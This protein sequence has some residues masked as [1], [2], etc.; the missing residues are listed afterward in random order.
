MGDQEWINATFLDVN[1]TFS[2]GKSYNAHV[3][4]G[5]NETHLFV[6]AIIFKAGPNPYTVPDYVTRPDGFQ[7]YFDVNNDANLA[8]PEAG[9]GLLNFIDIYQ[10][11]ISWDDSV[12][13]DYFWAPTYDPDQTKYWHESR[14]EIEGEYRWYDV[15]N[16]GN[17]YNK[18]YNISSLGRGSY[19]GGF[20]DGD[21][22]FEFCFPLNSEITFSNRL[23]LKAGETKTMGFC[24]E[25]YR[26]GFYFENGTR[27]PDL[28]DYWPGEGFTPN[29]VTNASQYAKMTVDLSLASNASP[30]STILVVAT[31]IAVLTIVLIVFWR[32]TTRRR[33]A[34][35]SVH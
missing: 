1:F 6:G 29:V 17:L 15:A 2:N 27:V 5:H 23:Q 28:Y 8:A 21:E 7:I 31:T 12:S 16:A 9:R 14:P 30:N 13:K 32:K 10:G 33:S 22:H 25:F 11:N 20:N 35:I 34:R 26:Q 3:Y 24:L 19:H 4:L 18:P